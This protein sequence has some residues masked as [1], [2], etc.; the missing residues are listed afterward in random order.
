MANHIRVA[1]LMTS[2][3]SGGVYGQLMHNVEL[4]NLNTVEQCE[5]ALLKLDEIESSEGFAMW[6]AMWVQSD[7][8]KDWAETH[9]REEMKKIKLGNYINKL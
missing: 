9:I 4:L 7:L 2:K 5:T 3:G 6:V 1:Y 8:R